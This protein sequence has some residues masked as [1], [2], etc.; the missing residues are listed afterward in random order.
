[1]AV[2]GCTIR[3]LWAAPLLSM[4]R[5]GA[6]FAQDSVGVTE[7]QRAHAALMILLLVVGGV[8]V[9]YGLLWVLRRRGGLPEEKPLPRPL[10][11]H[12]EDEKDKDEGG[13]E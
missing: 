11:V 8:L 5:A 9:L 10:W 12:P 4:L 6:A 3:R 13:R 1:M 7:A 2:T